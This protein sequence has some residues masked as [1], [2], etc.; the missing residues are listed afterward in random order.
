[1]GN[2]TARIPSSLFSE[3]DRGPEEGFIEAIIP[4]TLSRLADRASLPR[5]RVTYSQRQI[6]L[7]TALHDLYDLAR[8]AERDP[9][10]LHDLP[11]V[12]LVGSVPCRSSVEPLTTADEELL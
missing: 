10:S 5:S 11:H 12:S 6:D 9:R 3:R 2:E 8:V 7:F 4:S 1:M